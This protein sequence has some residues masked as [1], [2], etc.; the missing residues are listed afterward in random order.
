[1]AGFQ[2]DSILRD[3]ELA[4]ETV[5]RLDVLRDR[6]MPRAIVVPPDATTAEH[7]DLGAGRPARMPTE[8]TLETLRTGTLDAATEAIVRRFG[9][10]SLLIRN[11]TFEVPPADTW[12]AR[13]Y[14]TRSRLEHAIRS[15]GRV[16][17]RGMSIPHVGTAWLVADGIAITNRHVA[18]TFGQ[19]T[20]DG[21]FA[22]AST[23]IGQPFTVSLDFREEAIPTQPFEVE[24]AE[25]LYV[26]DQDDASP[27]IAL[28]RVRSIDQ[29]PLPAPVPLFDGEPRPGQ[30]VAAIGY[31]A[32]DPRNAY[33]DQARIFGGV[34]DIKRLAP[35]EIIGIHDGGIFSHDCTTL[36]GS[37]GSLVVDVETG[38]AAG[39]HFAGLYLE[40]NYAI[41]SSRIRGLLAQVDAGSAVVNLKPETVREPLPELEVP[42]AA[43][44]DRTGYASDFLGAGPL[45][46][47]MPTLTPQLDAKALVIDG[48]AAGMDRLLLK[49]EHFSLAMHAG[50]RMAIVTAVNVDGDKVCRLKR[51]PDIWAKD[52]RIDAT[53]QVSN[54]L[55]AGNDLDRG[56]LVRRLDPMWGPETVRAEQDTFFFTN[57]TPQHRQ[58]NQ[59]LWAELEDYLLENAETLDFKACIFTGPVFADT[60]PVYRDVALPGAFWKV[61]AMV[62]AAT[63]N[64]SVTAYVVS[65]ADLLTGLEFV[66]GQFRTYQVPVSRIESLTGLDFGQLKGG[67]PLNGQETLAA[68]ELISTNDISL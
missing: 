19:R 49:Y 20:A 48:S 31:P 6:S 53:R 55:Y 24:V 11:D 23:P 35:G 17:V 40:A 21:K 59:S 47:P 28:L 50:R 37:S 46:V 68:R 3:D 63:H 64:L 38:A 67:D 15:V 65:Q 57:C 8:G 18:L 61:V 29:R 27:D 16:E 42:A 1:M 12:K 10:P 32:E 14:P 44:A 13:L 30:V 56:H 25:I 41:T 58:F 60:D 5:R 45:A 62:D 51:K 33:L 52:P 7:R 4:L 66:Y 26:A 9:R 36:G 39:L 54:E 43:L 2:V 34:F 22:F